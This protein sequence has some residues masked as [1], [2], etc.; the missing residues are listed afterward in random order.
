MQFCWLDKCLTRGWKEDVQNVVKIVLKSQA[1][2]DDHYIT[3]SFSGYY[4]M[5]VLFI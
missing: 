2:A 3:C 4:D 5:G 1:K